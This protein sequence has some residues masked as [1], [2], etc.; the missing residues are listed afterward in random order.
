MTALSNRGLL[1]FRRSTTFPTHP[2]AS[3]LA[4]NGNLAMPRSWP[5]IS[6]ARICAISRTSSDSGDS[7]QR[8]LPANCGTL[9]RLQ[10]T[11][12][13]FSKAVAA[14]HKTLPWRLRSYRNG[15]QLWVARFSGSARYP[16][17]GLWQARRAPTA[18][19]YMMASESVALDAQG[20]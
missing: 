8:I 5:G 3:H 10:I 1:H 7:A 11:P 18:P 16:P 12:R 13:I 4:H 20:L 2:M 17:A 14:V 19:E 9:G 15:Y 6:T